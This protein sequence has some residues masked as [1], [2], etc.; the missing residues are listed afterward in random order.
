MPKYK[1][2]IKSYKMPHWLVIC[3]KCQIRSLRNMTYKDVESWELYSGVQTRK[4]L[5]LWCYYCNDG[6]GDYHI[7]EISEIPKSAIIMTEESL[8]I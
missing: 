1:N 5:P 6:D 8:Q 4:V 7:H 2:L 3:P